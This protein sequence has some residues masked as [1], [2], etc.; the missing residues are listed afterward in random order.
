MSSIKLLEGNISV[1]QV[2]PVKVWLQ[3]DS[4]YVN[5]FVNNDD[6]PVDPENPDEPVDPE[7]PDNP[8]VD[9]NEEP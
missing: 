5:Q 8:E 6:E 2:N 9:P 1:D 4:D 7:N 3:K